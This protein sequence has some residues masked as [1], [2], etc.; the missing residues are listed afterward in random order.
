MCGFTFIYH[1]EYCVRV[2]GTVREA[3]HI[4]KGVYLETSIMHIWLLKRIYP[5]FQKDHCNHL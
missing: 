3:N 4:L 2:I 5:Y 1:A